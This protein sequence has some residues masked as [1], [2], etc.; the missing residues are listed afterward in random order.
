MSRVREIQKTFIAADGNEFNSKAQAERHQAKLDAVDAFNAAKLKLAHAT[1]KAAIT[2]DGQLFDW[3]RLMG[4]H[5]YIANQWG[6]P[7]LH[8]VSLNG[9]YCQK[10]D[11]ESQLYQDEVA[12]KKALLA[13]REAKLAEYRLSIDQLTAEVARG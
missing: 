7:E 12:A 8:S 10:F 2:A 13:A 1:V 4:R 11:I 3:D 5:W 9:W 6:W